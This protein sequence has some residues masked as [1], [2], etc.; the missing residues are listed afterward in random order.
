MKLAIRLLSTFGIGRGRRD[1]LKELQNG[2]L[3][4]E[5]ALQMLRGESQT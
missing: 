4:A 3:T 2:N 5:E 1:I